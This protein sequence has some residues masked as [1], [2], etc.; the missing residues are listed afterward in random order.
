[1][2]SRPSDALGRE[3]IS[4]IL[5]FEYW[6]P[7]LFWLLITFLFSTDSFS[8]SESSRI[9]GPLLKFLFP[10]LSPNSI[11]VLHAAL[12][13]VGHISEYFVL[14]ILAY[15]VFHY[16]D[17]SSARAKA[18]TIVFVLIAALSDEIHQLF[19]ASRTGSPIDVGYDLSGA[20]LATWLL[21]KWKARQPLVAADGYRGVQ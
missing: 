9:L 5:I 1:M 7:L 2:V 19:T 18:F 21:S 6:L 13:K 15:R 12:R 11:A 14:G 20:V 16:D 10:F 4:R 3:G 8:F 17:R